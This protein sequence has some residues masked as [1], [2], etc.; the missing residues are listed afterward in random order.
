MLKL[1]CHCGQIRIAVQKR[2]EFI[3]ECNCSLCRKTGAR[4][5]YFHP[6]EVHVEGASSGYV[7]QDK[8]DAGAEIHF[9]PGCGSTTHFTL[10]EST[11]ARFGNSLTG[12]NLWLADES[13][14]AGIELRFPDGS[15]WSG[16]GDFGYVREARILGQ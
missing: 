15:R 16:E 4:W 11:I 7:R 14:L 10:T 1:S 2:P 9:C 8:D 12:V 6:S 3:H 5:G 13:D